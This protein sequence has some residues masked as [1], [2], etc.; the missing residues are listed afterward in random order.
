MSACFTG[1]SEVLSS[2]FVERSRIQLE[3]AGVEIVTHEN[4]AWLEPMLN[5]QGKCSIGEREISRAITQY[6]NELKDEEVRA[7]ATR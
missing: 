3:V 6:L 5:F 4:G 1:N 7:G 2:E